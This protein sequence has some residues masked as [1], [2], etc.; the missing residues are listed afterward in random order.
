MGVK[1]TEGHISIVLNL[2]GPVATVRQAYAFL[3]ALIWAVGLKFD[4]CAL[5]FKIVFRVNDMAA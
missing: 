4:T 5:H 2:N 1:L 3:A